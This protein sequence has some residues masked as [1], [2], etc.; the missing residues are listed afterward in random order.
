M[1][2][3]FWRAMGVYFAMLI[4]S[5]V[6][7]YV[8]DPTG[9]FATTQANAILMAVSIPLMAL[10]TYFYFDTPSLHP[11]A[12]AGFWFGAFTF[13]VSL[14]IGVVAA[15]AMPPME[16]MAEVPY[17]PLWFALGIASTLGVPAAVGHY[18]AKKK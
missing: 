8:I 7:G 15:M 2:L 9:Q 4:V 3:D 1:K 14:L 6:A 18:L 13:A 12:K 5:V 11:S 10:A 16:P 17:M